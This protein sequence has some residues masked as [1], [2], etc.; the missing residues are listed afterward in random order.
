ME[1][2]AQCNVRK[3]KE[4]NR[5]ACQLVVKRRT[6][7]HPPQITVKFVNGTGEVFNATSTSG[8]SIRTMHD[9]GEGATPRD[10]T[11]VLR[12]WCGLACLRPRRGAP[13]ACP[14]HQAKESRR[15][16]PVTLP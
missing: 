15:E 14:W 1:F 4:S 7:D 2:L 12:G 13:L 11:N 10:R 5:P 9:T 3:A 16:N 6:D 8:Q